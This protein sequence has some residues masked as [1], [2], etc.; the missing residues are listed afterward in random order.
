[1]TF[2]DGGA[3]DFHSSF[4]R[5]KETLSHAV[6]IARESGHLSGAG[7]DGGVGGAAVDMEALHLEQLP[8]YEEVTSTTAAVV[9]ASATTAPS[10]VPVSSSSSSYVRRPPPTR[11]TAE[12]AA[13][14][15]PVG[16]LGGSGGLGTVRG[17]LGG[18]GAQGRVSGGFSGAQGRAAEV[19]GVQTRTA[20][21]AP[22]PDEPPPGYE[23]AQQ[24]ALVRSLEASA[25]REG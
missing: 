16:G 21:L 24:S 8:A 12:M 19:A 23:E 20:P 3:F 6:E 2:K 13:G 17:P 22:E 1:M 5:V 14:E 10:P 15:R 25:G 7:A 11:T 18:S 4:E 9:G